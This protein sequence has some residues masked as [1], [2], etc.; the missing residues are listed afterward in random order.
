M[1]KADAL[2]AAVSGLLLVIIFPRLNLWPLAWVSL[3]PLLAASEGKSGAGGFKLGWVCGAVFHAGLVYWITVSMTTYGKLPLAASIPILLAFAAF[4]GLFTG[5]PLWAAC[6]AQQRRGWGFGLTLPFAWVAAEHLKSWFLTGFPWDLLGYSQY[7]VL[8]LIQ[9]ADITGVYGVSFLIIVANCA[10]YG[11]VRGLARRDRLPYAELALCA[12]LVAGS[13][14]YGE[15]RLRDIQAGPPGDE[16]RVALVQPDISQDVKWDP[17]YLDRTLEKF[18]RLSARAAEKS[19]RLIIWPESATPFFFQSEEL[20]R[21]RVADILRELKGA[22]L[23][24]GSPSWQESAGGETRYHNSAFLLGP[25]GEIAGRYDK[26]HLV[27]Y[28][29]YVPLAKLF[30]FIEKMVEGIGDFSPG[31]PAQLTRLPGCPFGTAICYEIIFPDLVRRFARDGARFLVNITND[32]WFG[33]TSAPH[34]HLAITALRAVESRRYIARC[35]N[36]GVSAVID[37]TGAVRRQTG[38]FTEAVL[39]APVYCRDELTFYAR[40]GDVFSWCCWAFTIALLLGA[41]RRKTT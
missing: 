25:G 18:A 23:L 2:Y 21:A 39:E 14:A 4:L 12:L 9:I 10:L 35:A 36:T 5:L 15:K 37:P 20:Y 31:E 1:K 16:V 29:E 7:R 41:R 8:P 28:G 34:Q 26:Q 27:P 6:H 32:A 30:P 17:A 3:V 22:H 11:V 24:L 19:P 38:L 40:S 33:D 13:W